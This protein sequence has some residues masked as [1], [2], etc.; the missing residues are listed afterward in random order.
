MRRVLR[1]P[2]RRGTS[3]DPTV[4]WWWTL[5]WRESVDCPSGVGIFRIQESV[6]DAIAAAL[7]EFDGL[8]L[9]AVA[10]P[11][12]REGDVAIFK[13]ALHFVEFRYE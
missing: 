10:T 8:G 12:G 7:P 4:Y 5:L 1:L 9:D 3:V 11:K 2:T 13:F 6:V